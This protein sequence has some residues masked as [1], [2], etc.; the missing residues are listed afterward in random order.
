MC[1]ILGQLNC[2]TT[3]DP[4]CFTRMLHTLQHRGPDGEGVSF[5]ADGC[6]ALGH[7]RLAIIDLSD[8]GKQPMCNE[9]GSIWVTCNGEI[10][11]Y[12]DLRSQ[13]QA[14]GHRFASQSDTEVLVHGYEEWGEQCVERLRGMF[15]FGIWDDAQKKLI[16]ARDHFG[17]K[18]LY[19]Y[20]D[21][22]QFI[23]ASEL[24]AIIA[25]PQVRRTLN[26]H[27]MCDFFFY[28]Y[29]PSPRTIWE[30]MFKLP[31]ASLLTYRE[32]HCTIRRYWEPSFTTAPAYEETALNDLA[33]AFADSVKMHMVSD[34][35]VGLLLSGGLDSSAI[36]YLMRH[37]DS[38]GAAFTAGFAVEDEWYN[39]LPDARL[40][41]EH[42]SM[43]LHEEMV[44]P[45]IWE[46]LPRLS[47]FYDEPFGD[48]SMFPSYLVSKL[49]RKH[50]KVALGGEGGDELFAGYN[51][52]F[53]PL[54]AAKA[55]TYFG[56][57][58]AALGVVAKQSE[59]MAY[60]MRMHPLMEVDDLKQLLHA[61]LHAEIDHQQEWFLER[62]YRPELPAPRKWQALD[63]LTILPE[64]YLTKVD[65]A[66][67][68][69]SLEL[70]VPFLDR[71]LVEAVFA[72]PV[73]AVAPA[74]ERKYLLRQLMK[75]NLPDRTLTKKKR[76]F[77]IPLDR[78][79]DERMLANAL[80]DGE[81]VKSGLIRKDYVGELAR[82]ANGVAL[83]RL[84]QMALFDAWYTRWAHPSFG[85]DA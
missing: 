35:P 5:F 38:R 41:A 30:G 45:D 25:C 44:K 13:L 52:Y 80:Q 9:D 81:S 84:W 68:A 76:G 65:R 8:N 70:R 31:P 15:A 66:S 50:M 37:E 64:Q 67:M 10:Y 21:P 29:I 78:F 4:G 55:G 34:V 36:A 26:T 23:F 28:R 58:G 72:L 60:Q 69:N 73:E 71:P 20:R 24:K 63:F 7:R 33:T 56:R 62:Y 61:D 83:N 1:G 18:P 16:L 53:E 51:R 85:K 12:K 32:G 47:W 59:T 43:E 49:A 46:L 14:K 74:A 40:V 77:S 11:N 54:P 19:Y 6:V 75:E 3:I 17:I 57:L 39:E 82:Q 79:F 2:Q 48:G 27:A 22:L 42:C